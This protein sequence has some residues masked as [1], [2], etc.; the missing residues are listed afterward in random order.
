MEPKSKRVL[1]CFIV[2]VLIV[3]HFTEAHE[4][5]VQ[6]DVDLN[7]DTSNYVDPHDML[8][9][10]PQ[11]IIST[12]TKR[13]IQTKLT[14]ENVVSVI[15]RNLVSKEAINVDTKPVK[16]DVIIEAA[17]AE[18]TTTPSV[19]KLKQSNLVKKEKEISTCPATDP[20][21][22]KEKPFLGRFVKTLSNTLQLEVYFQI[23]FTIISN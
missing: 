19:S 20:M 6:F 12:L 15:S 3:T 21:V 10:N 11:S 1:C 17:A 2:K 23:F 5:E 7:V 16:H 13:T 14:D 8:N 9:Y 18:P 22:S 4:E